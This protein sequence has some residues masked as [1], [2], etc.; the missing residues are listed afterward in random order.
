FG[1]SNVNAKQQLLSWL[2]DSSFLQPKEVIL[3]AMTIAC[4]NNKRKLNYVV[5]ILKNWENESLLTA[6]EIDAYH[7]NQKPVPNHR[8]ST[9]SLPAGRAIPSGFE[10]DLTAGEEW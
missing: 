6:Q 10:L 8:Q 9:E 7:E 4:A 1:F 3:K 2:D 5:G